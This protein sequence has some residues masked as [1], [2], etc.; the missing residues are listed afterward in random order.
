MR[1]HRNRVNGVV[2]AH[3]FRGHIENAFPE[4][5]LSGFTLLLGLFVLFALFI[6]LH[7]KCT[8]LVCVVANDVINFVR[9]RVYPDGE[10]YSGTEQATKTSI[11]CRG[12]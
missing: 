7:I 3:F 11:V 8:Q 12:L 4:F 6:L 5:L 1:L 9:Y 2:D 10:R